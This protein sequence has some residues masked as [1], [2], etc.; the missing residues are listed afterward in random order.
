MLNTAEDK[1]LADDQRDDWLAWG[2]YLSERQWGTVREDYSAGG[3]AWESF[4]H[5]HA[6][7]RAYR[8]GEDGIAGFSDARQRLCFGL[9]LWNGKD[10]ILKERLFGL[11]NSEGNHGEDV[12]EVYFYQDATPSHSWM[13]MLYRYPN[14]AYPYAELVAENARRK[15]GTGPAA[16]YELDDTGVFEE[17]GFCDVT[18][19]YAKRGPRDILVR[20]TAWNRADTDHSLH[21]L[22]TLWMRNTWSWA[23]GSARP[24]IRQVAPGVAETAHDDLEPYRL[25]APDADDLL[26]CENETNTARLYGQPGPRYPK[27]GIGEHVVLGADTVNP[28]RTGTKVAARH[29]LRLAAGERRAV[30][31]RLTTEAGAQDLGPDPAAVFE[32]RRAEAD[33]F[34]G[35]RLP[36]GVS[37]D[38]RSI[39]RQALAGLIWSKQYFNYS[40]AEWLDG[41][42][43]PP[44]QERLAGRNA[45]WRHF[46]AED[47]VSMPD[48]WEYPWFASWDLC[49]HAVALARVDLRF[50]KDQVLLLMREWYMHPD[51]QVPAYE[52]AFDDVNPPLQPWAALR[53]AAHELETTGRIDLEFLDAVFDHGLLYF[54]WWVNRKDAKDN[55]LFQGG[56]LG[57]DNISP[58]DRSAGYLPGGGRLYQSD[59][60]T[61]VGFFALQMMEIARL[62]SAREPSKALFA[63]KFLQH[64]AY[65]AD[66]MDHLSRE[67]NG[68]ATLWD[69]E[70]GLFYDVLEV[71]GRYVPLKVRSLVSLIPMIAAAEADIDAI[72][73]EEG[74]PFGSRLAR[75]RKSRS[76]LFERIARS[77]AGGAP[78][79]L[80][81]FL[82][83]EALRRMLATMLD[84]K[85]FLSPY[86]IRS[87][88]RRHRDAPFS[89]EITGTAFGVEYQPGESA[90][91]MFGGN[92]NWRGPI[93]MP[94]NHLIV[95]AL[96][97]YDDHYGDGFRV[98]CPTGSGVWMTLGEVADE[99]SR[100]LI[101]IFEPGADGVRPATGSGP[102]ARRAGDTDEILFH[103]YFHGDT[104]AGLGAS[105]QTGW[106]ALVAVLIEEQA[107]RAAR[108]GEAHA[109]GGHPRSD[110]LAAW[111]ED[112]SADDTPVAPPEP[113]PPIRPTGT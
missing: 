64:F 105:H 85:E 111:A 18:V 20:I 13:R 15:A 49:F 84:E 62:L 82:S 59:G 32:Q 94:I 40:V 98:E 99:L 90:S 28:D 106:T 56:F 92:S 26:F 51:G 77:D 37:P 67:T 3:T 71:D 14:A 35:A 66:A 47:I 95:D 110:P 10:A 22:P 91:G 87:V 78:T 38:R 42:D 63:G 65:I 34:H 5:D 79:T 101:S 75:F 89:I 69:E 21:L 25:I 17:A 4:P 86:G 55:N 44:P 93:W 11:T 52:W 1:R 33:A 24:A 41:D 48:C 23:E 61:W 50:A 29:V 112:A 9:A 100:R 58:F 7:S 70:D 45:R 109:P 60:T 76:A 104:G 2:P 108:S 83:P 54:T 102:S 53:I 73:R 27:D 43:F 31:L 107:L 80:M 72:G 97:I 103:E 16:E 19:E 88:S 113:A 8:W 68:S 30:L 46:A 96:R 12:K 57:L 74:A 39:A 36:A 6:R 81:S